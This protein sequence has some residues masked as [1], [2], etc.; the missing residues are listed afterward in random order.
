[1]QWLALD[2]GGANLKVADGQQYAFSQSF[3]LWQK[4]RSLPDALRNLLSAAPRA[5][6]LAVTMTGE[7]P[8][9]SRRA[10]K[11]CSSSS[12]Q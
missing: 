10:A 11:G 1:M 9:A 6:H 2:I 12:K 5:D 3:P 4:H 8:I 7:L